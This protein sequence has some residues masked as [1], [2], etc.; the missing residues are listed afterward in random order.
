MVNNM[1]LRLNICESVEPISASNKCFDF[2]TDGGYIGRAEKNDW[3]LPDTKKL[4][5]KQHIRVVFYDGNFFIQDLSTNGVWVEDEK[6]EQGIDCMISHDQKISFGEYKMLASLH[7]EV[8][9]SGS[10]PVRLLDDSVAISEPLGEVGVLGLAEKPATSSMNMSTSAESMPLL[11]ETQASNEDAVALNTA[12]AECQVP[13]EQILCE[14]VDLLRGHTGL[15]VDVS[16]LLSVLKEV[17]ELS[18]QSLSGIHRSLMMFRYKHPRQYVD[19]A[20]SVPEVDKLLTK[21]CVE[22][23]FNTSRKLTPHL[24]NQPMLGG[25]VTL[26]ISIMLKNNMHSSSVEEDLV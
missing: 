3:V 26:L 9:Q 13:A 20:S 24:I 16:N 15:D 23:D 10:V 12:S 11:N 7:Q 17:C 2:G 4:I 14:V 19:L 8:E 5:S 1:F 21:M 18:N 6:I 25:M 22:E